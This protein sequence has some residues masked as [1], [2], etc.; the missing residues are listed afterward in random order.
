MAM[1]LTKT[2]DGNGVCT[3]AV[4][5]EIDLYSSPNL[6]TAITD[7]A[8]TASK[9]ICINLGSVEYMDSSGVATLVEG[10]RAAMERKIEFVLV[11]PSP[12][13]L[14]VLQLSRLDTV[15]TIR[16]KA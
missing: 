14:K 3:I 6:R 8:P 1:E 13:V 7:S 16:D 4:S 15:F 9:T 2:D 11:A 10:L 5:G 12:P